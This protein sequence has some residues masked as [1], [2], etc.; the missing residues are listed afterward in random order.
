MIGHQN[1]STVLEYALTQLEKPGFYLG[2]D[3][4]NPLES[5]VAEDNIVSLVLQGTAIEL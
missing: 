2:F 3:R 4:V 5:P 1:N